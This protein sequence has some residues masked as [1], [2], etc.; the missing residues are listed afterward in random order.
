MSRDE[1]TVAH[2]ERC[3]D[4]QGRDRTPA[5]A[6][7]REQ[8]CQQRAAD[9]RA[10]SVMDRDQRRPARRDVIGHRVQ[11]RLLACMP[12]RA[13]V[14]DRPQLR[15]AGG[16]RDLVGALAILGSRHQHDV[17]DRAAALEGDE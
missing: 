5:L 7:G 4:R 6:R 2:E 12:R 13:T 17:V 14:D 3:P 10:C 8:A 15:D 9:E 11:P 1:R 16:R